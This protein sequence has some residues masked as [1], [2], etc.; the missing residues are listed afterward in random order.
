[1]H[2]A[3]LMVAQAAGSKENIEQA[4]RS[5]EVLIGALYEHI[6]WEVKITWQEPTVTQAPADV[7]YLFADAALTET[8]RQRL[9]G[10]P[11]FKVGIGW[12][13]NPKYVAD[14][15]RSIPLR[16]FAPLARLPG[17]RL[18][19]LQKG[20][21]VEQLAEAAGNF[22]VFDFG[23]EF[24]T[25]GGTFMDTAAVMRNLDLVVTSDTAL[26][27]LAGGL[28]VPVWV[29]LGFSC[30]WRWLDERE[31]SPWYPTMRLFRKRQRI[32]RGRWA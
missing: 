16:H 30:D 8:W 7:P 19:S 32:A 5:A 2:Q 18:F 11:G 23:A 17:V 14:R 3:Q 13:G 28:G 4:K 25:Q 31:D 12:Q 22:T 15:L 21:G 20:P 1:M 9:A 29:A 26:A 6:G 24:D 10:H 27:H